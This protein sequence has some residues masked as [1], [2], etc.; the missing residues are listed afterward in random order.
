MKIKLKIKNASGSATFIKKLKIK[1]G[2]IK[3]KGTP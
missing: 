1:K 2:V 3:V